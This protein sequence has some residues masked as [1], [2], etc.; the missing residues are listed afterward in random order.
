MRR[1]GQRG[2]AVASVLGCVGAN[3]TLEACGR[4]ASLRDDAAADA[5]PP[6]TPTICDDIKSHMSGAADGTYTLYIGGMQASPGRPSV[7]AWRIHPTS[8]YR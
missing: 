7:L 2:L 1:N 5:P 4:V 3:T 6:F 8:T